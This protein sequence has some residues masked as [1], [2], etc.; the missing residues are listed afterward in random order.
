LPKSWKV[1][2]QKLHVGIAWA[3]SELNLINRHRS[4]PLTYFFDLAR[5]KGVQLYSLQIDQ[6]KIKEMN[7]MGGGAFIRDLSSYVRDVTDTISLLRDLDLVITC[8]SALGHI[9][10]TIGKE[11]FIPYSQL[12]KDYRIGYVGE[13]RLWTPNHHIFNQGYTQRWDSAF[14]KIEQELAKKVRASQ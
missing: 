11:C 12:G 2:D 8:E 13:D 3:G 10:A 4:I 5:I 14:E 6:H 7:D 9:C 1:P